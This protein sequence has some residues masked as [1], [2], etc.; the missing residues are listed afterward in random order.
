MQ[1][2]K[3]NEVKQQAGFSLE[4]INIEGFAPMPSP[5]EIKKM[6]P[7]TEAA[8]ENVNKSRN[9]IKQILTGEDNRLMVITGPCSEGGPGLR[10]AFGRT[11]RTHLR[12]NL[13]GHARVFREA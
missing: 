9:Q 1:T 13:P 8:A 12:D 2:P 4:D 11:L 7:L 6:A 3:L 10:S 5:A